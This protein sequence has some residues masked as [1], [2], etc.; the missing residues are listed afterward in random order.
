MNRRFEALDAFRG[1]C[2]IFVVVYHMSFAES[3]TELGFFRGSAIFV[4]FFFALSGFVLA[5]GY[6][7][8]D[9]LKFFTF[10]KS[11]FFRLYPLHAFMFF[12]MF[13][14]EVGNLLAY[15]IG[16]FISSKEPFTAS[17]DIQE[18]IPNLLLIQSWTPYTEPLSFNGPSWS[19]SIEFYM[20]ALL[21]GSIITFRKNKEIAWLISSI[22]AFLLIYLQSSIVTSEVLRGISC[23]FG[24]AFAYFLFVRTPTLNINKTIGTIIEILLLIMIIATVQTTFDHRSL[25][26][27]LLFIVTV[28]CFAFELGAI[29]G[30]FKAKPFQ[31]IGKLSYSI[32]M[33]HFAIISCLKVAATLIQKITKIPLTTTSETGVGLDFGSATSNNIMIF[34]TLIIVIAISNITYKYIEVTGQKLSVSNN[35]QNFHLQQET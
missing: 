35:K 26:A 6:A 2:A 23:F 31:V 32:Y 21:F 9:N 22:T 3:I 25:V 1:I 14:L 33:T 24:G 27:S 30:L 8:K 20:Y 7:Y 4:E 12:V 11:R 18:I 5:H 34:I 10:M 17:K 28:F 19:I 29:S 13:T 16:G 15:E